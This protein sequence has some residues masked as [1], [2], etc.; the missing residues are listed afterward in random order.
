[1]AYGSWLQGSSTQ[2]SGG[3]LQLT[4]GTVMI[5]NGSMV[6]DSSAYHRGGAFLV[7]SGQLSILAGSGVVDSSCG[8]FDW[9]EGGA[10]Q[11]DGGTVLVSSSLIARSS[12]VMGRRD[13]V[14]RSD[15][16]GVG[17]GG[18]CASLWGGELHLLNTTVEHSTSATEWGQIVTLSGSQKSTRRRPAP[19]RHIYHVPAAR[20]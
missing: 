12:V 7:S 15:G 6:A 11:L 16:L 4:G 14:V 2:Q 8:R 10:M 5:G 9:G 1:M 18:G 3:A 17:G 20:M 19:H 13:E